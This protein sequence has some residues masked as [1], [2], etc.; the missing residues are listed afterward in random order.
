MRAADHAWDWCRKKDGAEPGTRIQREWEMCSFNGSFTLSAE[1]ALCEAA[2]LES[3]VMAAI[4]VCVGAFCAIRFRVILIVVASVVLL[5]T[6]II[7]ASLSESWTVSTQI[8]KLM[9][10]MQFGYVASAL[11]QDIFHRR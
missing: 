8:I 2:S 4:S 1:H 11:L 6:S 10:L 9:I 3:F 7:V 5:V